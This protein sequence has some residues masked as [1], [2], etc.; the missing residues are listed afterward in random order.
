MCFSVEREELA[1]RDLELRV[2]LQLGYVLGDLGL[3][4]HAGRLECLLRD[5]PLRVLQSAARLVRLGPRPA[6]RT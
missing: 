2:R 1:Q 3:L 4:G 5:T 6:A